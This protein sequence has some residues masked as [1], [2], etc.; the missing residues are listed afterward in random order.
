V[1]VKGGRGEGARS[2]GVHV[3]LKLPVDSRPHTIDIESF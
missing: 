2:V 3:G 1:C